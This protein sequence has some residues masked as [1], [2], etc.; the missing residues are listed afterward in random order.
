MGY[1]ILIVIVIIS[2]VA[3][4]FALMIG[5]KVKRRYWELYHAVVSGNRQI[6]IF[7][8]EMRQFKGDM[9]QFEG[10]MRLL[11]EDVGQIRH[12]LLLEI[13]S[14]KITEISKDR[15]IDDPSAD[16]IRELFYS[17]K[18]ENLQGKKPEKE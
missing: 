1:F 4:I 11:K 12:H 16:K 18:V 3:I 9:K 13:L 5:N 6:D 8:V 7:E 17:L 14:D 10:E 2:A 15:L